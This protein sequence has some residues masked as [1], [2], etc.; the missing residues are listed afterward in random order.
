M[1]RGGERGM[2]S[3]LQLTGVLAVFFSMAGFVWL[4]RRHFA[5]R[6]GLPPSRFRWISGGIVGFGIA[7]T[8]VAWLVVRASLAPVIFLGRLEGTVG[9]REGEPAVMRTARF[10]VFHP[11][12]EHRVD[13]GAVPE[14]GVAV[15]GPVRLRLSLV[16]P[17]ESELADTDLVLPVRSQRSWWSVKAGWDRREVAFRP[18]V[19]GRYAVRLVPLHPGIGRLEVKVTELRGAAG[20]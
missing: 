13:V 7:F 14:R 1:I 19:A 15:R 16:G 20:R 8:V 17:G 2:P 4:M 12:R 9:M 5:R 11:G 3:A 18:L 10:E 6:Y